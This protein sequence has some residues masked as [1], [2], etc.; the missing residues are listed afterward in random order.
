MC[1]QESGKTMCFVLCFVFG[2]VLFSVV[3]GVVLVVLGVV[4]EQVKVA[5]RA[6]ATGAKKTTPRTTK[7]TAG[8]RIKKYFGPEIF[9]NRGIF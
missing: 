5:Q 1:I 2:F 3:R 9:F 7:T 8:K 4:L 6:T